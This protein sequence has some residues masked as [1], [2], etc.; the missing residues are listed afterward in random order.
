MVSKTL[1]KENMYIDVLPLFL[2][3][4]SVNMSSSSKETALKSF[5]MELIHLFYFLRQHRVLINISKVHCKNILSKNWREWSYNPPP[6]GT[7]VR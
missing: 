4:M 2:S 7:Y 3:R 6:G 5:I 1:L